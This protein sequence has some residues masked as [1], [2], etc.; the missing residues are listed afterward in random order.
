MQE[1]TDRCEHP[2]RGQ[3]RLQCTDAPAKS[4]SRKFADFFLQ[5]G[6]PIRSQRHRAARAE[7]PYD[8]WRLSEGEPAGA[9]MGTLENLQVL[10]AL[11]PISK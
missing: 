10:L 2:C 11:P 7:L 8:A 9:P 5:G 6:L 1:R 3:R 4:G